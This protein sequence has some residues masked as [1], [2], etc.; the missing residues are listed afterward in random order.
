MS[1]E[2]ILIIL[3]WLNINVLLTLGWIVFL[4]NKLKAHTHNLYICPMVS[5]GYIV[6]SDVCILGMCFIRVH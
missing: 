5:I 2:I 4:L 3:V 1:Q 6:L